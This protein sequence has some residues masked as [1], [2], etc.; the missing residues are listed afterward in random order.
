MKKILGF[1]VMVGFLVLPVQA[2][3]NNTLHTFS[4]GETISSNKVN[5]NFVL[6]SNYIVKAN[7][8]KIGDLI[9][10]DGGIITFLNDKGY[11]VSVTGAGKIQPISSQGNYH[12][13]ANN[14][15]TGQKI[16]PMEEAF[17]GTV[18]SHQDGNLYMTSKNGNINPENTFYRGNTSGYCMSSG[19]DESMNVTINDSYLTG[20]SD[21]YQLPIQI[22]K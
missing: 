4:S 5:Q 6:T 13:F 19:Y 14:A 20:V 12:Y 17:P 1:M 16:M 15:C 7:G 11:L 2:T 3:D 8:E 9:S 18:F 21:N 10:I 22:T